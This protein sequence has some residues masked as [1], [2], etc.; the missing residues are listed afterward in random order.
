MP[1]PQPGHEEHSEEGDKEECGKEVQVEL[2]AWPA[3]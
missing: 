1:K 3:E 2:P